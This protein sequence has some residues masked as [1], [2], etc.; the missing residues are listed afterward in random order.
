[1]IV[2]IAKVADFAQFLKV[3]STKGVEKRKQHGCTG[4]H[5]FRDP[6]DPSRVWVFF[7]WLIEDY[8]KFL[9]DP[10]IPAIAR[11][12]ALQDPPV[13]AE[14]VAQY[15]PDKPHRPYQQWGAHPDSARP[16]RQPFGLPKDDECSVPERAAKERRAG[17]TYR[18]LR[19]HDRGRSG[20][21][22]ASDTDRAPDAD[23]RDVAGMFAELESTRER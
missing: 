7:D 3:L 8:E 4:S 1:M 2:T 23:G 19:D 17:R 14:P 11:E 5:V 18:R 12:L 13:K 9:A 20:L 21:P 22:P 6:E 10:E 15:A 16:I